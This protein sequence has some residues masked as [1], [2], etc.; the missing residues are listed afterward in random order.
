M[1][2]T[3]KTKEEREFLLECENQEMKDRIWK[4]YKKNWKTPFPDGPQKIFII[5]GDTH[6]GAVITKVWPEKG[7]DRQ[8]GKDITFDRVFSTWQEFA[9]WHVNNFEDIRWS[10]W[11]CDMEDSDDEDSDGHT[12]AYREWSQMCDKKLFKAMTDP[13]AV[14][15]VMF[16]V[17]SNPLVYWLNTVR[18][19]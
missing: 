3:Q 6:E 17:A 1:I 5:S 15:P 2:K 12:P 7:F 8:T 16:A 11:W 9:Q 18:G 19:F 10:D 13:T 14:N 4:D